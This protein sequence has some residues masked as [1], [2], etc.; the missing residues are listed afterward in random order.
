M[1]FGR[2]YDYYDWF[3]GAWWRCPPATPPQKLGRVGQ[4]PPGYQINNGTSNLRKHCHRPDQTCWP[5]L[6]NIINVRIMNVR[7]CSFFSCRFTAVDAVGVNKQPLWNHQPVVILLFIF[8]VIICCFFILNLF[9]GVVLEKFTELQQAQTASSVFVTPQQQI[10]VDVQ[11]LLLRTSM[12]LRPARPAEERIWQRQLY[13]IVNSWLFNNSIL[14]VIIINVLFMAMVHVDM[15]ATWQICMSYSNLLFTCIFVVEAL[16]KMLAYGLRPF[17]RDNWNVFDVFVVVISIVSVILDFSNTKN[18]SFMPVLR[19]LRVVRVFRL[20]SWVNGLQR[21]LGTLVHSLPALANVGG[22]LLLFFFIFAVIGMNLFGGMK[23]GDYINRHANFDNF[24]NAML[25]LMRMI[26]GESWSGIMQACMVTHDCILVTQNTISPATNTTL[27]AGRYLDP[28]D[29]LLDG[30]PSDY[31]KNQCPI[32]AAAAIIFFPLF[33]ILCGL[34]LLNLII[35]VILENMFILETDEG[36][37][38]GKSLIGQFVDA[39]SG[40]DHAAGGY[41]HASKLPMVLMQIDQPMGT[42]GLGNGRSVTQAVIMSVDIPVHRNNTPPKLLQMFTH[43]FSIRL[44]TFVETLHALAGRVA[45]T[46]LP[47][48]EEEW[49]MERFGRRLPEGGS[50]FPK[51]TAAHFHAALY[52]QAAVRGFM[53][54]HKMRGMMQTFAGK[55]EARSEGVD[56]RRTAGV[57]A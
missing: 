17:F 33:V 38:V 44:V 43:R 49:L 22:V 3:W 6:A 26:T 4:C 19:V 18:L 41:I 57:P 13:D 23:Y 47:E 25:V 16:M 51:Y 21:L 9:I 50:T 35:A 12:Q 30:V 5:Q 39:W 40:I 14:A 24:P 27:L 20:L 46:E 54:R 34:V 56:L 15:S 42:K 1:C 29:P 2:N 28:G 32:S 45:G 7:A 55:P 53:A 48:I 10:W 11:K 37:P 52:V 36:L 31:L 8:F